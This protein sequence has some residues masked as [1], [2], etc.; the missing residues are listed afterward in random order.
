MERTIK[1]GHAIA[2]YESLMTL[3]MG[4][5][6][7][8]E[9]GKVMDNVM[10][11]QPHYEMYQKLMQ[12][13]GKR[14]Y[15]GK[16]QDELT[17]FNE[18]IQNAQKQDGIAKRVEALEAVKAEYPE[19]FGLLNKQMTVEANLKDKDIKVEFTEV[20]KK[21]FVAAILA[22]RPKASIAEVEV[23]FAPLF[24]EEE[25]EEV[26]TDFSELDELMAEK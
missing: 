2:M 17:A 8:E 16:E 25:K 13:L 20:D 9:L 26:E 10:A 14:L 18:K 19:L 4:S 21:A 7:A 11:L 23:F 1:R 6:V 3:G 15:E 22:S 5:L 12:E 24:A